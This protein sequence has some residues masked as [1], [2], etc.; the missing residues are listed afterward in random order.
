MPK[1]TP[2]PGL[3]GLLMVRTGQ[4]YR[5]HSGPSLEW[6]HHVAA[7]SRPQGL[8]ALIAITISRRHERKRHRCEVLAIL[9]AFVVLLGHVLITATKPHVHAVGPH[10]KRD[11]LD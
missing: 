11:D 8:A 7:S 3:P 9:D 1:T 6:T 10:R 4:L 2:A 5:A